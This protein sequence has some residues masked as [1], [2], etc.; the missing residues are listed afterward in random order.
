MNCILLFLALLCHT[1]PMIL[2]FAT[3]AAGGS[4]TNA[5]NVLVVHPTRNEDGSDVLVLSRASSFLMLFAYLAFLIFHLFSSSLT[6]PPPPPPPPPQVLS[7]FL[8]LKT[9]HNCNYLVL[10]SKLNI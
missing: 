1:L 4:A 2:R 5:T 8:S 9:L 10:V 7:P 6:P 3:E